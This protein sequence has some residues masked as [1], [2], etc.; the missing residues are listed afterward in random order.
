MAFLESIVADR[1]AVVLIEDIHWADASSV[2]AIGKLKIT[3]R[4]SHSSDAGPLL[5]RLAGPTGAGADDD[6]DDDD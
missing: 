1:P 3:R 4:A 6:E 2:E 5:P